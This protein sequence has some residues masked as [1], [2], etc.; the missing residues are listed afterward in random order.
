MHL[1]ETQRHCQSMVQEYERSLKKQDWD[2]VCRTGTTFL[3]W[4]LPTYNAKTPNWVI[5]CNTARK[6]VPL[7]FLK[8]HGGR[9]LISR[10]RLSLILTP[11]KFNTSFLSE[12]SAYSILTKIIR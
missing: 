12:S 2:M 11:V 3:D 5:C 10:D 1:G 7:H 4:A 6:G 8:K 9:Q